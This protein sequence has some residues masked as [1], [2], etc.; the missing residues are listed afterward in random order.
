MTA[1]IT[2]PNPFYVLLNRAVTHSLDGIWRFAQDP[3]DRG[4]ADGWPRT[5]A[6]GRPC[7]VPGTSRSTTSVTTG[8][9]CGTSA[10]T[11]LPRTRADGSPPAPLQTTFDGRSRGFVTVP[12]FHRLLHFVPDDVRTNPHVAGQDRLLPTAE[13]DARWKGPITQTTSPGAPPTP[14]DHE[15]CTLFSIQLALNV[16][17]SSS[18]LCRADRFLLLPPNVENFPAIFTLSTVNLD[19]ASSTTFSPQSPFEASPVG[20]VITTPHP[21]PLSV[22]N[23]PR[24]ASSEPDTRLYLDFGLSVAGGYRPAPLT[25]TSLPTATVS[26]T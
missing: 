26:K 19:S 1:P 9:R 11:A 21:L 20:N 6:Q 10:H 24:N 18:A 14:R 12:R 23:S 13:P 4:E 22:S 8:R 3:D 16:K 15:P 2:R 7:P 25:S 17:I 5:G